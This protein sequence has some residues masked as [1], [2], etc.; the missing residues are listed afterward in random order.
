MS[1]S[2]SVLLL[3]GLLTGCSASTVSVNDPSQ[4]RYAPDNEAGISGEV[5]Y[6]NAG[7]KSVRNVRRQDAYEKMY[8]W[9]NGEYEIVKEEDQRGALCPEQRRIWFKCAK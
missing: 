2:Q 7:A 4:S 1:R 6:C 9:C 3:L 8:A 5:S